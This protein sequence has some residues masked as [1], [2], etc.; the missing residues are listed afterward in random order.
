[1]SNKEF[2]NWIAD[3]L[4]HVYGESPNVDFVHKL[5]AIAEAEKQEP[6]AYM[7]PDD[8]KEFE[9]REMSAHAYSLEMVSPTQGETVPLYTTPQ[10]APQGEA[11]GLSQQKP[12]TDELMK[13]IWYGTGS[14]MGWYSFQEVAR[15]IEAAHGIK[16]NT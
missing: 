2:L 13:K 7:Y 5:R 12:L 14:I 11:R 4:V 10:P 16:E 3:R 9:T 1:M 8:L 15:A 6:V